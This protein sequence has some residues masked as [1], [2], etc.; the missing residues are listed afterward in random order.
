MCFMSFGNKQI[1]RLKKPDGFDLDGCPP[2]VTIEPFMRTVRY[3][4]ALVAHVASL[5]NTSLS[6]GKQGV[7]NAV[8]V[9]ALWMTFFVLNHR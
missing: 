5:R 9:A 3:M 4:S 1:R 2:V 8:H 7:G 6:A